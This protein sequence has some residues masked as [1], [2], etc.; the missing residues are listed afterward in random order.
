MPQ[1]P[2][3]AGHQRPLCVDVDG[4]LV[5]TDLLHESVFAL[6]KQNFLDIFRLPFWLLK[7]KAHLKSQIAD[8]VEIDVGV[9]PYNQPFLDYL[10]EQHAGGRRL[11]LATASNIRLAEAIAAHIGIFDDVLASDSETNLSGSRKVESLI[12]KYGKRGFDYAGNGHV[13]KKVWEHST[14]AI[15]VNP[16]RG[17]VEAMPD[18]TPVSRTFDDRVAQLPGYVKAMRPQQWLKNLL[19]FV[20]LLLAHRIQEPQLLV[21]ASLAFTAFGLCASSVYLLNDLLDLSADRHH[22]SKRMRP[23]AAGSIS[24]LGGAIL[25]PV[26][27]IASVSIAATLPIEFQATLAVYYV[28]TLSYS[29]RLKRAAI[30]DVLALAVLYTLR[31]IAGAAAISVAP[32]FW[33]LAFSMFLFLSLAL[34]KRFTELSGIEGLETVKGRGYR[35]V[36]QPVTYHDVH[37]TILHLLGIDHEQLTYLFNGRD[38]RLTD[39]HG[40]LIPQIVG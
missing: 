14:E 7:S 30:I 8:R 40:E 33:I 35:A 5:R 20:P 39:V 19:L 36:E 26:L 2:A 25:S 27:L 9:L 1:T 18:D 28:I 16:S 10:H 12:A 15:L 32:S 24:I 6:I 17:L 38:M 37:A 21:R 13:D 22:P 23:F 31:I 4:T 29:I 11:I 34:V 3:E